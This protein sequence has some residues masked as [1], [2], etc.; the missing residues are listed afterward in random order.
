M[1]SNSWQPKHHCHDYTQDIGKHYTNTAFSL[2]SIPK[3]DAA[4]PQR[5]LRGRVLHR[6]PWANYVGVNPTELQYPLHWDPA[7][8]EDMEDYEQYS[9]IT[10][11]RRATLPASATGATILRG[12]LRLLSAFVDYKC[13][14]MFLLPLTTI[15]TLLGVTL[16]FFDINDNGQSFP[17]DVVLLAVS[18]GISSVLAR[19][20]TKWLDKTADA[21]FRKNGGWNK[22]GQLCR[23]S[24]MVTTL[25]GD[26][27]FYE[28]DPHIESN[29]SQ[30]GRTCGLKLTHRYPY[31]S[32]PEG[33]KHPLDL[34]ISEPGDD[35]EQ[36][37]AWDALCRYMDVAQ[38]LPDI[39]ALEAFRHLDPTTRVFDEAGKR[40]KPSTYWRDLYASTT[41]QELEE[42][43]KKHREL[44]DSAPWAGRADL[45]E[46]SVSN[47]SDCRGG[48][49][50]R[51]NA[52]WQ[53]PWVKGAAFVH[54][55][56]AT[57]DDIPSRGSKSIH[58]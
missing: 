38:P 53:A 6:L 2:G 8:S 10:H 1:T 56:A 44:V 11:E 17:T 43:R 37:A 30:A 46:L 25:C 50:E 32:T 51:V 48:E 3:Q 12:G 5:H 31:R 33:Q 29:F 58:D 9:H 24:G 21:H 34:N 13:L 49:P 42:L 22:V 23:T 20:V 4:P 36:Y 28:F 39:P 45:M 14:G 47:F 41:K 16:W 52:T 57:E 19:Q 40:G 26:F 35:A 54:R 7:S 15:I 18:V 27:P 55:P